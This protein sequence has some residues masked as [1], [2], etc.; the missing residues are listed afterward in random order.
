MSRD[1]VSEKVH[2][3]NSAGDK[4][5]SSLSVNMIALGVLDVA[6]DCPGQVGHP[7]HTQLLRQ[8][9]LRRKGYSQGK[10]VEKCRLNNKDSV[11]FQ[12]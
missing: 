10:V 6:G 2:N 9:L 1:A 8:I 4:K 12:F 11:S 3:K 5:H 7:L